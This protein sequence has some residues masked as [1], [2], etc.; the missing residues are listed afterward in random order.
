MANY[1]V[2]GGAGFI[3]SNI[4]EHLLDQGDSVRVLDDFSTGKRANLTPFADRIELIES[5]M[6]D[7]GACRRAVADMDYVLHQAAMASVPRSIDDPLGTSEINVM[8]TLNLLQAAREAKVRRLVYAAS[9]SAYGDQPTPAKSEQLLPMPL[10][11]Y[12]SAK[13]AVFGDRY[14]GASRAGQPGMTS[15]DSR[16]PVTELLQSGDTFISRDHRQLRH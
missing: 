11:P 13:L 12:A 2:T 15:S 10:S 7:L 6:R 9:S 3:G 4:V 16:Y 1:L 8:G 5:D 14:R